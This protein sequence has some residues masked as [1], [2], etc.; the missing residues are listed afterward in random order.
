M[1]DQLAHWFVQRCDE[2]WEHSYGVKIETLDNPGWSV[3]IDLMGTSLESRE[4][5]EIREGD[6]ADNFDESGREIGK[7][8]VCKRDGSR[9]VGVCDARSLS[10][11]LEVFLDWSAVS[12]GAG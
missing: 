12:E 4:F 5:S 1:I 3:V 7:W 9:F 10:R 6:G 2:E 11:V 8:M